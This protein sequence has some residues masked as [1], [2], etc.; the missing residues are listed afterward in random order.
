MRFRKPGFITAQ[1]QVQ[2]PWNDIAVV[3]TVSLMSEDAAATVVKFDGSP[4]TV[5]THRSTEVSDSSG[6]RAATMVFTGDNKAYLT[7]KDGNTTLELKT[8]TARATEFTT[9]ESM[10][11]KLPPTSAFT[12]CAELSVDGAERVK[13]EKPVVM[14]VDNFLGF[15]VGGVVPVGYFDRDHGRL[16]PGG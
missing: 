6:T 15:P 9:P 2:V 16:G 12:W 5:V 14:W 3:E 1:R 7:D 8:I 10:P 4:A 13:F 11:A